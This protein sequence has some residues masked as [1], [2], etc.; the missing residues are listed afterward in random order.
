MRRLRLVGG[1][2]GRRLDSVCLRRSSQLEYICL[3]TKDKRRR[4]PK[5]DAKGRRKTIA[6]CQNEKRRRIKRRLTIVKFGGLVLLWEIQ[7]TTRLSACLE[8]LIDCKNR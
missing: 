3:Y 6:E 8:E 5:N 4:T 2:G 1:V 7:D